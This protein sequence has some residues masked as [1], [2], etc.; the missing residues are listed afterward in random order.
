MV[1][2]TAILSQN[3]DYIMLSNN[4]ITLSDLHEQSEDIETYQSSIKEM[5]YRE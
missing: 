4:E 3:K 1:F 5:P 2:I